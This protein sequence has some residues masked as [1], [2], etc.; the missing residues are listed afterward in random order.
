MRRFVLAPFALVLIAAL[1]PAAA[2]AKGASEAT[3]TGPGLDEPISLAGEGQVGGKKLMQLAEE[4]G[5]F[6]S[7][8][9]TSPDPMLDAKPEGRLGPRYEIT[10]V[11]PGPDN[12]LDRLTQDLY[13][14]ASP[15]PISYME[16][17]Q[18]YFGT[19]RTRG[20]W[21]VASRTLKSSLVAAGLPA[22][23]PADG[24]GSDLPWTVIGVLAALGLSVVAAVW[25]GLRFRR[26]PGPATA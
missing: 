4:A 6:P 15:S 13:P 21:Y 26:R 9:A 23:S 16:P 5:F 7:V 8:F 12:A 1:A 25:A 20:G 22:V 11:M 2:L 19:E 18:R 24:G 10:Y 14:F 17:G 3:I